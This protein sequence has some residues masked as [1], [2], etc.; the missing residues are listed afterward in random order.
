MNTVGSRIRFRRRQLKLTQKDVA[1]YLGISASAVTQWERDVT[2][3]SGENLLR[4]SQVLSCSPE[5]IVS[6]GGEIESSA[7]AVI[8]SV[9]V[10][11]LLS[12]VQAGNWTEAMAKQ[13]QSEWVKTSAKISEDAFALR[14]KGDSM[15]SAGSLSIPD[16]AIVIVDP[17]NGFADEAVGKIVIAQTNAGHD[18]TIKKLVVD[19]PHSYLLPLNDKFKPID[20]DQTTRLI[21]IVRQV[22]IDLP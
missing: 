10:V 19:G 3:P 18:A 11:P 12:W 14:V 16:G 20:V 17:L 2:V 6:G 9:R 1:E 21:G 5:W 15:T 7:K 4:L 13:S 22:I 8:S